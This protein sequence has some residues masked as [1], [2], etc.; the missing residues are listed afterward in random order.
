MSA[1][2]HAGASPAV[3]STAESVELAIVER[4][5]FVE[6]RHAGSAVVLGPDGDIVRTLG[7]P[8]KPVFPRSSM[9]PFQAVAVMGAG[10]P[11][12]G[13]SAVLATASHAGTPAHLSVVRKLLA[14]AQLTEDALRCPADWP[15]DTAARD[16]LVRAGEH[17]HPLYMNCSGK[18]AAM[19]LAC[20][21]NGWPT[22]SY[23]DPQHPMQ[24]HIRDTVERFT[25]EKVVATGIDGC[26]APVHAMS[27]LSLARGI[28]RIATASEGSPFALFRNAALLKNAVLA[29]GWA[30]DGPGR[31]N[32]VVIDELGVFA[33]G[34][35]EGVMVMAAPDGTTVTLKVLDGS[36]RAASIVALRL[37][38][39]A[40]A[41]SHDDVDRVA[42]KL[43]LAVLGRGEPVGAIR[44]SYA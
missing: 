23:L 42:P 22:E 20:R 33:K 14:Q 25:G 17:K 39:D 27:L 30:I 28:Q 13:A 21:V 41:L 7:A 8:D 34:G 19:L 11:L 4:S 5:R 9:K 18:H 38:A 43:D 6:S 44:P 3:F 2:P 37:L 26:G 1:E 24:Q 32:T 40:G 35:A 29:D 12:E 10:V 16:E 15:L 36:L 31:A